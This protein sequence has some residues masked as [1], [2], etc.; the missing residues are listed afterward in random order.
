ML[1]TIKSFMERYALITG[2]A[3]RVGRSICEKFA[4]QGYNIIITYNSSSEE[5]LSLKNIVQGYGKKCILHQCDFSDGKNVG[6]EFAKIFAGKENITLV[7]NNAAIFE[8]YTISETSEDIFDRH[9]NINFKA[10]FLITQKYH[11]YCKSH[12]LQGHVINILDSYIS[13]NNSAYFPYFLSKKVLHEF[14]MMAARNLGPQLRVNAVSI[15]LLL[16]SGSFSNEIIDKKSTEFPLGS[17][18]KI[19]DITSA[20]C[21]L[22]GATNVTGQNIFVDSGHHLI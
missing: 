12:N 2:G 16:A 17:R 1:L 13:T 21:Y 8:K 14:T 5:A 22:E 19:D 7:V 20:I 10:P 18:I 6:I 15:G 9:F 11:E 4:E 3:V